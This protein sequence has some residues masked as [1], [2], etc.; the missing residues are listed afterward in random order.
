MV[1]NQRNLYRWPY[2]ANAKFPPSIMK[3]FSDLLFWIEPGFVLFIEF[4]TGELVNA[5]S[6]NLPSVG[7]S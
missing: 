7:F 2:L 4:V 6:I 3:L 5:L 1:E